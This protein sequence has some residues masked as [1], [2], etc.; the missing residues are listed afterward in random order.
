MSNEEKTFSKTLINWEITC[1]DK[2]SV[3]T[4]FI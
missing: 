1:Y 2:T 4:Y 3:N